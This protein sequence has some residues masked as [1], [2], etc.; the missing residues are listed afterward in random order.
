METVIIPK[1]KYERLK[2]QAQLDRKLLRELLSGFLDI[3][4]K[5][6]RRVR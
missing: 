5:Q 2:R 1:Q 4:K 6:V 3:K